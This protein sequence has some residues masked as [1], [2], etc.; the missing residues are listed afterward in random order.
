MLFDKK[1]P[2]NIINKIHKL[3]SIIAK[4]LRVLIAKELRVL[5]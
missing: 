3:L 5:M 2:V 4:E 1:F